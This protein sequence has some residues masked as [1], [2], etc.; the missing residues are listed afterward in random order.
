MSNLYNEMFLENAF[1][2]GLTEGEK[3]GLSGDELENFAEKYA[4]D[5]FEREA[6]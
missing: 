4:N 1:D 2:E 3:L 5:K 6:Q